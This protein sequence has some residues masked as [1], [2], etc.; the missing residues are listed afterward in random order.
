MDYD[1]VSG[2]IQLVASMKMEW[3]DEMKTITGTTFKEALQTVFV[4]FDQIWTPK[5]VL[6]SA[7]DSVESIGDKTYKVRF[8]VR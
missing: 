5:L 2:R 3:L 4:S 7:V 6:M 8:N 1:E